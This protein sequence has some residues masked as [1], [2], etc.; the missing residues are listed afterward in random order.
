MML[1]IGW[2]FRILLAL[3]I[4]RLVLRAVLGD[5]RPR[6][7]QAPPRKRVE[8]AGGQLVRD[9]Q[10]GTYVPQSRAIVAGRGATALHFCSTG[11]RD[12]YLAAHGQRHAS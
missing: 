5:R 8:R 10:C 6:A 11:C 2:L 3:I 1:W 4:L 12:Q 7:R 9:P